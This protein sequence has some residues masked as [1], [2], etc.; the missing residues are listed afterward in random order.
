MSRAVA[1]VA[2]VLLVA[3]VVAAEEPAPT[4]AAG[5]TG[6]T[7]VEGAPE[8]TVQT[9]EIVGAP[10]DLTGRWFLLADLAFQNNPA[11][12]LVPAFWS[13]SNVNGTMDVEV[14]FVGLPANVAAAYRKAAETRTSWTPTPADLDAIR[15]QWDALPAEDRGFANLAVKLVGRDAFDDVIKGEPL[16]QD[17]LWVAQLTGNFRP[18]GGRPVREVVI[19]GA[20]E[21]IENGWSGTYMSVAVANA[22]FPV[23]IQLSGTF[24]MWRVDPRPARGILARIADWFAGCGRKP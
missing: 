8:A 12:I 21:Q 23:P 1:S 7:V 13:V 2:A 19:F 3:F 20:K 17:A 11:R 5:T 16:V 10:P 14:R 24:R 6:T 22:P 4:P 15:D 9:T 18:G